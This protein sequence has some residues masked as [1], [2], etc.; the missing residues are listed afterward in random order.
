MKN[1]I[2]RAAVVSYLETLLWSETLS[3]DISFDDIEAS[4]GDA[5]DSVIDVS[6]LSNMKDGLDLIDEAQKDLEDFRDSCLQDLGINPFEF[7]DARQVAHDFA[8]SRNGHGAGFFDRTYKIVANLAGVELTHNLSDELQRVAEY[9]GT[10]GLDVWV[11]EDGS[12]L[13]ITSHN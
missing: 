7:F 10:H 6:D 8:L 11:E 5:L 2:S 1:E 9:A 13:R 4:E 12:A 3:Q